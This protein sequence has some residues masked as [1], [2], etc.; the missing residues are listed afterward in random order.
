MGNRAASPV[1]PRFS[2]RLTLAE[3]HDSGFKR[4]AKRPHV[5]FYH[6]SDKS[7]PCC[8]EWVSRLE[9][10]K[11]DCCVALPIILVSVD[12]FFQSYFNSWFWVVVFL[13][14][15]P[16]LG[17]RSWVIVYVRNEGY[18]DRKGPF[19]QTQNKCEG[20]PGIYH[21]DSCWVTVG[22]AIMTKQNYMVAC[23]GM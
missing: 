2:G 6:P 3:F 11:N 15:N 1:G 22:L 20:F 18:P 12:I 13:R 8:D 17:E 16:P 21:L 19:K 14:R 5:W 9:A 7:S 10:E 4:K 23:V